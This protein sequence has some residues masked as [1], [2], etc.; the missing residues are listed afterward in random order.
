[1][2][3]FAALTGYTEAKFKSFKKSVLLHSSEVCCKLRKQCTVNN[4]QHYKPLHQ[5]LAL[6]PKTNGKPGHAGDQGPEYRPCTTVFMD[7]LRQISEVAVVPRR[8]L[9]RKE[10]LCPSLYV[11]FSIWRTLPSSFWSAT[12]QNYI[13]R[14]RATE[15]HWLRCNCHWRSTF[16]KCCQGGFALLSEVCDVHGSCNFI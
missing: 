8:A 12:K 11:S 9:N 7:K 1:M 14:L 13:K 2:K 16:N 10:S 6:L 4:R 3:Y 15:N 5:T